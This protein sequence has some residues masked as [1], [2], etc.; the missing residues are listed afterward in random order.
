MHKKIEEIKDANKKF[1]E[2]VNKLKEYN[3]KVSQ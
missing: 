3:E 1:E 2:F